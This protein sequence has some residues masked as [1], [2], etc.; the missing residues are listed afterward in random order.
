MPLIKLMLICLIMLSLSA[1]QNQ[2]SEETQYQALKLFPAGKKFTGYTLTDQ[3][4]NSFTEENFKNKISVVFFGFTYCPDICPTTLTDMQAIYKNIKDA[5]LQT[6]QFVFISVDP[7]RDDIATLKNYI[8]YFNKD[9]VAATSDAANILSL[10][11]QLGVAYLVEKHETDDKSYQV[12][13][14]AS[15]F[16]I[17]QQAERIGLF[18]APHDVKLLSDD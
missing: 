11:T 3:H 17:N 8:E 14:S 6:P 15:L 7:D 9:F 4:G 12:D 1:C 18:S 10:T 16:V 13:H 5:G 2:N